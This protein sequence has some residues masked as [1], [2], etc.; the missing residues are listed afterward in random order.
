MDASRIRQGEMIAAVAAVALFIIMFLSWYSAP[1][2]SEAIDSARDQ[3][4]RMEE[5]GVPAEQ[6][7]AAEA[8]LDE[9]DDNS[10]AN[11][12][13]AFDFIDIILLL[14]IIAAIALLQFRRVRRRSTSRLR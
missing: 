9:A 8:A 5:A 7:D 3:I 14:T 11:A 13:R 4:D 12:W 10:S 1:G 6:I 2:S